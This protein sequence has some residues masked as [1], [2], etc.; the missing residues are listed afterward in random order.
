MTTGR[1]LGA[2][3]AAAVAA[4]VIAAAVQW[5]PLTTQPFGTAAPMQL[6]TVHGVAGV[7]DTDA[8]M[9]MRS[10]RAWTTA[11][12]IVAAGAPADGQRDVLAHG[13][14]DL[15]VKCMKYPRTLTA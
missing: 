12:D 1:V 4:S 13:G 14:T 11:D 9:M 2:A 7:A 8:T 3:V 15:Q 6:W 5:R 10:A